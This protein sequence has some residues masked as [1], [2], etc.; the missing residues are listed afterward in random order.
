MNE[1]LDLK[2]S[3]K[4]IDTKILKLYNKSKKDNY[5]INKI[6][7]IKI[8]IN[9]VKDCLEELNDLINDLDNKN[10]EHTL[11]EYKKTKKMWDTFFP[12]MMLYRMNMDMDMDKIV[13]VEEI[14]NKI[15]NNFITI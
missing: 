8:K 4:H 15:P 5:E 13:T 11:E 14:K 6:N 10:I 7:N 12:Y 3:L 1:I 9:E 2:N